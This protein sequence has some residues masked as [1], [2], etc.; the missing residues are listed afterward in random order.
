M[1]DA[2][3]IKIGFRAWLMLLSAFASLPMI[4]F[5]VMSLVFLLDTQRDAEKEQ[6][7]RAATA[8]SSNIERHLAS[9]ASMLVALANSDAARNNDLA[10]LY[11]HALRLVS[12]TPELF[13]IDLV[14]NKGII[15]F[16][17]LRPYGEPLPETRDL[18][19][20][21]R[22]I[23][24]GRP[25]VSAAYEGSVSHQQV[26]SLGVAVFVDDQARY[27]LRA[28]VPVAELKT[29]LSQQHLHEGWSA[30]ILEGT[31]PIAI[32]NTFFLKGNV[33]QRTGID[34]TT[35]GTHQ[36]INNEHGQE[37]IETALVEVGNWGWQAAV[38]VPESAF[39]KPL[40]HMLVKFGVA[41]GVC[42][43]EGLYA[44]Y[45]LACR[46]GR[47]VSTIAAASTS[48]PGEQ[49]ISGQ[50]TI[51]REIGEVRACLMAARDREEKALIDPLTGIPG[52][53]RF[54]ELARELER[55]SRSNMDLGLAVMFIDLD[56][57]KQVND[58]FGHD[59]GDWLLRDVAVIIRE[60][61]RDTDVIGRLGGDEFAVGLTARCGHLVPAASSI[62]ARI[63]EKVGKLGEDIGCSIGVSVCETCSP[64]LS[65]A[66]ALADQAMYEA[67]RL[68]KNR[69]VI[70]EDATQE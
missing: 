7:V 11:G 69:Y 35:I 31:A 50:G 33:P 3:Q 9:R 21:I 52:R 57:F 29:I 22:V 25:M 28:I 49:A 16:H 17:T 53:G 43:L 15:I 54:W 63:V 37:L 6:L 61:V 42:L 67:K 58:T 48:L 51:I 18:S 59:Q 13:S 40:R 26:T 60:S 66:L 56:G 19:S 68:G 47:E 65:R 38:S 1:R 24:T 27:C 41:G 4:F 20:A 44:S 70:R 12:S 23:E 62:A 36:S 2:T 5:S 46:L 8:L 32:Q 10:A 64:N 34:E 39:A 30:A 45:W 14:D 55:E